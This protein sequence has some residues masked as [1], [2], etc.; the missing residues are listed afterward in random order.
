MKHWRFII[1]KDVKKM[2][3]G[4]GEH[5]LLVAA[6]LVELPGVERALCGISSLHNQQAVERSSR[7]H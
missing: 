7:A 5:R 2:E 4:E 3:S 6:A 1:T